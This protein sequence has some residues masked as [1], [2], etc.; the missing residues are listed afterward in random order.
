MLVF[1]VGTIKVLKVA[2]TEETTTVTA[3]I[4]GTKTFLPENQKPY[5]EKFKKRL[6]IQRA[7]YPEKR[8]ADGEFFAEKDCPSCGANFMPDENYCCSFCGYGLQVNNAKWIVKK[9]I[10]G[11]SKHGTI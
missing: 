3:D 9:S 10:N 2:H 11:G 6:I 8:K 5:T 7:R 4:F 1:I